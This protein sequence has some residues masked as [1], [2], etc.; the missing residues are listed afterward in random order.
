MVGTGALPTDQVP[1]ASPPLPSRNPHQ[2]AKSRKTS[3][4]FNGRNDF[5]QENKNTSFSAVGRLGDNLGKPMVTLFENAFAKVKVP[6][7]QLP[8]CFGVKR[9]Q[10]SRE[11]LS[12]A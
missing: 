8:P 10:V 2:T 5:L 4:L 11:T 6:F 12:F 7:D 9:V 1:P 3:Q